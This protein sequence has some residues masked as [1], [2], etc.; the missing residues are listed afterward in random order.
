MKR[1]FVNCM[2]VLLV[3]ILAMSA[4]C[5]SKDNDN[6][7][8]VNDDGKGLNDDYQ[9]TNVNSGTDSND[10]KT[11]N[12]DSDNDDKKTINSDSQ[13]NSDGKKTINSD[14]AAESHGSKAVTIIYDANKDFNKNNAGPVWF[15]EVTNYEGGWEKVTEY[16]EEWDGFFGIGAYGNA[17]VYGGGSCSGLA[18]S[19]E[20]SMST[21][22]AVSYTFMCP[23]SGD[24]TIPE[25]FL[26]SKSDPSAKGV[27][28]S[29]VHNDKE[30]WSATFDKSG[31]DAGGKAVPEQ[32]LSVNKGDIIRFKGNSLDT[33]SGNNGSFV[34]NIQVIYT[35][36]REGE[37]A[38][39]NTDTNSNDEGNSGSVMLKNGS[40]RYS[41][42]NYAMW[43]AWSVAVGN[44]IHLVHLKN[45]KGGVSYDK[46]KE[47]MRGYGH[48]V[49]NDLLHWREQEDILPV[50]GLPFDQEFRYTGSTIE[51]NGTYYTYYTTR[52]G[53]FQRIGVAT[54]KDMYNWIEY[55]KNPILVPDERWF[56]TY[57]T[58][59]A[60]NNPKWDDSVDCRDFVVVEDPKGDGFWGYFVSSADRG[61]TTPTSVVGVAYSKDLFNWEQMGIAYKPTGVTMPEMMDVFVYKGKWYMTISTAKNNGNLSSISDPFVTRA[62][63]YMTANSP[64]GPFVENPLDNVLMG[65][66]L[67]SGCCS[68][69][70]DFK[71][72]KRV[73]YT[74]GNGGNSVISLPKDIGVDAKGNL[75]LY[76]SDDILPSL[77]IGK[78]DTAIAKQPT[79][80]FAWETRGGVWKKNGTGFS[81][82][83]DKDSWQAFLMKGMSA[84]LEMSFSVTSDSKF[85]SFG[86]VLS[87]RGDGNVLG[88]LNHILSIDKDRDLIYLTNSSWD[89][90]NCRQYDFKDKTEYNFRFLFVGN[91]LELYI[92]NELVFNSGVV[93]GGANRT[94]LFVNNGNITVKDMELFGLE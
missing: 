72:K 34:W 88:D 82:T 71:G 87:N 75:R 33:T 11:V 22:H 69:T 86:I 31:K 58:D 52:K 2:G 24:I 89:M 30:I 79:N 9:A 84:N 46:A 76:Y 62:Q 3:M 92:N 4:G 94:G 57:A 56:I 78:L 73:L 49:T 61:L 40:I 23:E 43:D 70:I 65:G 19:F 47:D 50:T 21:T 18:P 5:A 91:T 44:E 45:L 16:H 74:D 66:Q 38:V 64:K 93:G 37:D 83:T 32:K 26:E 13:T 85:T 14:S 60:S 59:N 55:S 81:C 80:T 68:R 17:G 20:S 8:A 54:S 29:I 35:N 6:I 36:I 63:I 53:K 42:M 7:Q 27:V 10:K 51:H 90:K 39:S 1:V 41:P 12:S 77:R 48:A 67:D 28:A 25:A 15:Y